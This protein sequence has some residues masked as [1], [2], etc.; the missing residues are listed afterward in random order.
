MSI[1]K[2]DDFNAAALAFC[3]FL[4]LSSFLQILYLA[5]LD[6][7]QLPFMDATLLVLEPLIFCISKL[8][9]G[10]RKKAF[11]ART[12]ILF[13]IQSIQFES[14]SDIASTTSRKN[15]KRSKLKNVISIRAT[16]DSDR[17]NRREGNERD[18]HQRV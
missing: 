10:Q 9:P 15:K 13:H 3:E 7:A 14:K 4:A 12:H 8:S 6:D 2:R 5:A 1:H 17:A 16:L 11:N 18:V